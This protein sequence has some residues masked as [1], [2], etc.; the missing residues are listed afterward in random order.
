MEKS[1]THTNTRISP[2]LTHSQCAPTSAVRDTSLG[3]AT[4]MY[5]HT[6]QIQSHPETESIVFPPS[7]AM[8]YTNRA[9]H[10]VHTS[11]YTK[12]HALDSNS[13]TVVG[14][15]VHFINSLFKLPTQS[16]VVVVWLKNFEGERVR[17]FVRHTNISCTDSTSVS[18]P[19][20][21]HHQHQQQRTNTPEITRVHSPSA[22]RSS[23]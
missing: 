2:P 19:F 23:H 15:L 13:E 17:T 16:V 3:N 22:F 21:E 10:I 1:N 6:H 11:H 18:R 9:T 20:T 8:Q 14:A 7:Y 5:T 12:N 4:P